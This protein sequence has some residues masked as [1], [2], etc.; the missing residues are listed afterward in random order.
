MRKVT[1]IAATA[2]LSSCSMGPVHVEEDFGRS[3][4]Q[5]IEGQIA[6]PEAAAAPSPLGPELLD[7]VGAERSLTEYRRGSRGGDGA[8]PVVRTSVD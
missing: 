4:R 6:D 8:P 1:G 3:V 5:M 2:L 7:G